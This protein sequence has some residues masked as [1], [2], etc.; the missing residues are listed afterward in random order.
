M[1]KPVIFLIGVV[2]SCSLVP[3]VFADKIMS[4][5]ETL[6]AIN[7]GDLVLCTTDVVNDT[8]TKQVSMVVKIAMIVDIN[9]SGSKKL[10]GKILEEKTLKEGMV[11]EYAEFKTTC[12]LI[13]VVKDEE[14]RKNII[15]DILVRG[16]PMR[17]V[18]S[19]QTSATPTPESP[20]ATPR[21]TYL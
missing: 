9:H 17:A 8:E 5:E 20:L 13:M 3:S 2:F 21:K 14:E 4:A 19:Y 1:K 6:K 15:S 7:S 16:V 10:G 12:E 18:F 11:K